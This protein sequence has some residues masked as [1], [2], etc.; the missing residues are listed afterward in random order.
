MLLVS[1]ALFIPAT[2]RDAVTIHKLYTG[3]PDYFRI[4]SI[5]MPT[6][7]EVEREL[8]MARQDSRRRIELILADQRIK[9]I[10]HPMGNVV[11]YLDYKLDYPHSGEAMV[12][13]LMISAQLQSSGLGRQAVKDLEERLKGR[14]KRVLVSIYGQNHRAERFWK[15]LGY[16]FA[17]DAKPILDWYGKNL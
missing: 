13:L 17:I 1:P 7:E 6:L 4:I 15:S 14:V 11:G 3:T 10:E 12:N 9:G 16:S 8:E 5:P 2:P